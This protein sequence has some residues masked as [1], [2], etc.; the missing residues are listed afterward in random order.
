MIVG[1]VSAMLSERS[2]ADL[3]TLRESKTA[4]ISTVINHEYQELPRCS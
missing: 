2:D 1:F 4:L 3:L